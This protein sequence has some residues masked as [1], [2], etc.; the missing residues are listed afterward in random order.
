MPYVF[1]PFSADR[2]AYRVFKGTKE[3]ALTPKPLDLLFYLLERPGTLV[4]KE[5]LLDEVWPGANVTENALAQAISELRDALDDEASAPT[6]VR[7]VAR[8]GYRFIAPV[9]TS[10]AASPTQQPIAAVPSTLGVPQALAV[11][12]FTNVTGDSEVAWLAAG[13]AETVTTDFA[14]LDHFRVVDRWRVVQAARRVGASL[15]DVAAA[16]GADLIVAGSYQRNGPHLRITARVVNV[17]KG[18]AVA[19][20]KVD[21]RLDEVFALQDGIVSTFAR[22]LGVPGV[23]ASGSVGVRETSS[24][25]AYRAY[26]E[27]W[28]KIESLDTNLV[29]AAVQDFEA[30]IR[31]DSAFAM[32]YTGLANAEFVAY[33]M[34]RVTTAPNYTALQSGIGHARQAIRLEPRLAEAHSTLSFL[35]VSD[36]AF[37]EARAAARQAVALEPHSWRHQYR[38]GHATWGADRLHALERTLALYPQFA[39]AHLETAMLLVARGDFDAA[40]RIARAGVREQDRQARSGNRFPAIGFHWLLGA[41]EAQAGRYEDAVA[42]F[43]H[44]IGQADTRRLYGPEYA[45]VALSARGHT[46]LASNRPADA[47]ATF[48]SARTHLA[49]SARATIGE[50]T[51]LAKLGQNDAA[52][53]AWRHVEV[54]RAHLERTGRT[55]EAL[56]VRACESSMRGEP[57]AAVASL[58]QFLA[59]VPPSHVGWT[60][61]IEPCFRALKGDARFRTVLSRLAERAR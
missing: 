4:T 7:T 18:E 8:R 6:Y 36:M 37:D 26:I 54:G 34:T 11:V 52:R 31:A 53:D 58:E 27:G 5:E 30:A 10:S 49:E 23:P 17:V 46:E 43:A 13:I 55:P 28:L 47:L 14:S 42:E 35:L 29:G 32:A 24:L 16:V 56:L 9:T 21:G 39:Y 41:L 12:D 59:V 15:H 25:D 60:I 1:G 3:L 40:E 2:A 61:P 45:A 57:A 38:L 33:E 19:D 48:R 44:E 20:A 50:A 51:A 22:E